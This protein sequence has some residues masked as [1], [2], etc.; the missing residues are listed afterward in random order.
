MLPRVD[1]HQGHQRA[2]DGV[3]VGARDD[4]EGAALL[5][6][7][8][9]RPAGALDAGQGGGDLLAEGLEG[10]EVLLDRFLLRRKKKRAL[11]LRSRHLPAC[12]ADMGH[13]GQGE[14]G[15]REKHAP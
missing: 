11:V 3:L 7:D 8:Q 5:V 1:A 10:A 15:R 9:P 12:R 2:G 4:A 6:L 13:K 14:D